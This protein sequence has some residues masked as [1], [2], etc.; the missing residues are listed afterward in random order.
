MSPSGVL[1]FSID[2]QVG[3]IMHGGQSGATLLCRGAWA[4]K[5][6]KLRP[7]KGFAAP[8]SVKRILKVFG[9]F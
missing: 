6:E 4:G 2:R 8:R 3:A 7:I 1:F 5:P 9:V